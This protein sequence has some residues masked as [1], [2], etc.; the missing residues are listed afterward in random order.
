MLQDTNV[1][2]A[3]QLINGPYREVL[4]LGGMTIG[5]LVTIVTWLALFAWRPCPTAQGGPRRVERQSLML[6]LNATVTERRG[7]RMDVWAPLPVAGAAPE[8]FPLVLYMA[9][10]G[11]GREVGQCEGKFLASHGFLVVATDDVMADQAYADP[12]DEAAR[13]AWLDVSS[14]AAYEQ[15]MTLAPRRALLAARKLTSMIDTL[16]Q[17]PGLLRLPQ[18]VRVATDRVGIV[19]FSFGG[20]AAAEAAILDKRIVAIANLD[21]WLF[22]AAADAVLPAPYLVFNSGESLPDPAALD[23]HD[24]EARYNARLNLAEQH[25]QATQV[26]QRADA[27]RLLVAGSQ[28]GDFQS[29]SAQWRRWLGYLKHWPHRPTPTQVRRIL[30]DHLLAFFTAHLKLEGSPIPEKSPEAYPHL[31]RLGARPFE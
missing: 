24:R 31:R 30:N 25:R 20:A 4:L 3:A 11:M 7:A 1:N 15:T 12:L 13:A 6:E 27:I 29:G 5:A 2:R 19:G 26:A 28:H 8:Q 21:G 9:G 23:G 10:W 14:D 17:S 16:A 18:G 22:G